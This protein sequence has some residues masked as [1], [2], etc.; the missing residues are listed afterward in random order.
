MFYVPGDGSPSTRVTEIYQETIC[1]FFPASSARDK[2]KQI[3]TYFWVAAFS[4]TEVHLLPQIQVE[5]NWNR[6]SKTQILQGTHPEK[7]PAS[8]KVRQKHKGCHALYL[9]GGNSMEKNWGEILQMLCSAV[10]LLPPACRL[11]A[12]VT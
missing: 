8:K 12:Y 11:S 9:Q 3:L 1:C 4:E 5:S 10:S 6:K 7:I 2:A